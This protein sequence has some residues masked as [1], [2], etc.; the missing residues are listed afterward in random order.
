VPNIVT[1]EGPIDPGAGMTFTDPSGFNAG[2]SS[3]SSGSN[4]LASADFAGIG[5]A[6]KDIFGGI[7][8]LQEASA[9]NTAAKYSQ[10]NATIEQ[11]SERIQTTQAQ[12][13][14]NQVLGAQQAEAG[15]AGLASK[16]SI[17][18]VVR[19]SAS[20]GALQKAIIQEQGQIK[21]EGYEQAAAQ[22]KSMASAADTAAIG[23]FISAPLSIFS[24][25][26][27]KH[28]VNFSYARPDGIGIYTFSYKGSKDVWSGVVAQD[29]QRIRPD[30]VGMEDGY[31]T[32]DYN[33]LGLLPLKVA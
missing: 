18:N 26:R 24:D 7:G 11:E 17:L 25:E 8:D 31:L 33:K 32:V 3:A 2:A 28:N 30:A 21:V 13:H 29:V 15:G 19:N 10:I 27:L 4:P 5:G 22:Y 20:Q 16:G 12:R 23:S 14:L 1:T 6:V 9:Y